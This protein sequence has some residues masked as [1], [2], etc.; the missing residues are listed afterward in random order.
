[1]GYNF[2]ADSNFEKGN[3]TQQKKIG[4]LN[5]EFFRFMLGFKGLIHRQI[6]L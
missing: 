3:Q 1:M 6:K 5:G 2:N 4:D